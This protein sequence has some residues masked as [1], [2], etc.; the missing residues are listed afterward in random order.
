MPTPM[1]QV[2][3][4]FMARSERLSRLADDMPRERRRRRFEAYVRDALTES[5]RVFILHGD[6]AHRDPATATTLW[7]TEKFSTRWPPSPD[8]IRRMGGTDAI[9][10]R[11]TE[12]GLGIDDRLGIWNGGFFRGLEMSG[13]L[14]RYGRRS[15][16]IW[17]NSHRDLIRDMEGMEVFN[18]LERNSGR[19]GI[20]R[21]R[22]CPATFLPA[23]PC[24]G[25]A[26]VAGLFSGAVL[27]RIEDDD[28]MVLP[29]SGDVTGILGKWG[30]LWR[31]GS[32]YR[33]R[34]TIKVSPFYAPLFI[35]V[36]P[37][38][39]LAG[40]LAVRRPAMCP[41]LP[42][43]YWDLSLSE[44]GLPIA[45]FAG[46]L[47]FSCSPRSFRRWGWKRQAMHLT[48]IRMGI[49]RV[50]PRLRHRLQA[51]WDAQSRLRASK[52]STSTIARTPDEDHG[53]PRIGPGTVNDPAGVPSCPT[54]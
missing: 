17:G 26:V 38:H 43:I 6:R 18:R 50:E 37:T 47:P 14:R 35:D 20:R 36:M 51:W 41:F 33:G 10:H 49:P 48:G 21:L 8:Q 7:R 52:G 16:W 53:L 34:E 29:G 31:P 54:G 5:A 27:R 30:I 39:T 1:Q 4:E 44:P 22:R 23:E 28:W 46:A 45:P 12:G 32:R 9:Y 15:W 2:L 42:A 25:D 19:N 24:D 13:A 11:I 40:L 3:D